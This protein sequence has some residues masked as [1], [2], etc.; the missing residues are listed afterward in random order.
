MQTTLDDITSVLVF[1]EVVS[2][3]SYSV[4]AKKLGLSKSAVSKRV[5]ALEERMGVR[6]LTRTTR[7]LALTEAGSTLYERCG[8]LRGDADEAMEEATSLH[9]VPRG[10]LRVNAA[11]TLACRYMAPLIPEFLSRHPGLSL[12]LAAVD[13][14]I[15]PVAEGFDIVLRVGKQSESS[16]T[17][18]KIATARR[19][20]VG[21]PAY[22]ARHGVPREP[23][24][25]ASHNC[26]RFTHIP[27]RDEWRF[28]DPS[29]KE[30]SVP[31]KTTFF[32]NGAETIV[33]AVLAS[34]GLAVLP[35]FT[36]A[37]ELKSGQLQVVLGEWMPPAVGVYAMHGHQRQAPA[38]V[39]AFLDFFTERLRP[40][41]SAA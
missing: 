27:M 12:E 23:R 24:E 32:A 16:L 33:P 22:L 18:R 39:R 20:V 9:Q 13:R 35:A 41:L 8:R 37:T 40:V 25:L 14:N 38:K 17:S 36:V 3:G 26:V 21:A 2:A 29:G 31:V 19:V 1:A 34:V 7:R 4:A 28:A 6:L 10:L 30:F 5:S 11:A 15:D